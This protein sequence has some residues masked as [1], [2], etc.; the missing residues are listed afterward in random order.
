MTDNVVEGSYKE[1]LLLDSG[2]PIEAKISDFALETAVILQNLDTF[3]QI[4][5]LDDLFEALNIGTRDR[6]DFLLS[7]IMREIITYEKEEESET[8][9]INVSN[10]HVYVEIPLRGMYTKLSKEGNFQKVTKIGFIKE[11]HYK[12]SRDAM[13]VV[14]FLGAIVLDPRN[15]DYSEGVTP[16]IKSFG[17]LKNPENLDD[18]KPYL[19]FKGNTDVFICGNRK[20]SLTNGILGEHGEAKPIPSFS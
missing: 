10:S 11:K 4:E 3:P 17:T 8:N 16:T 2:E 20:Y 12:D 19:I 1:I 9:P 18:L 15:L 14:P 7:E 5:R 6:T 13:K